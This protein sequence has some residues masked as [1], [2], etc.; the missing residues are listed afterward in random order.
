MVFTRA[1]KINLYDVNQEKNE[2]KLV[3]TTSLNYPIVS[4]RPDRKNRCFYA[5]FADFNFIIS[6]LKNSDNVCKIDS[7]H[8]F[9]DDFK[10]E[11]YEF[12]QQLVES[13]NVE[14]RETY[15]MRNGT[16]LLSFLIVE[17]YEKLIEE[18]LE[19]I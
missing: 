11:K 3:H 8:A 17:G 18:F 7:W 4:V 19:K 6:D 15:Q 1:G 10:D 14:K 2:L 5:S 9:R 13:V 16:I 12:W